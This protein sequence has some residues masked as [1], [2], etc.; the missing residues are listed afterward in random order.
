MLPTFEHSISITVKGQ[1]ISSNKS[2]VLEVATDYLT[3]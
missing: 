3:S 1:N 2:P